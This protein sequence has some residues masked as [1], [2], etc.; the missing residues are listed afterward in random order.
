MPDAYTLCQPCWAELHLISGAVCDGCARP[1]PV[2]VDLAA[3]WA[4]DRTNERLH[5]DECA[6]SLFGWRRVRA[7]AF[8]E[9]SARSLVLALKHGDRPDLA[10]PLARWMARAGQAMIADADLIVP[11]PLHW[12]RRVQR[13]T[14]QAAELS[15]SIARIAKIGHG[16]GVLRRSV[17]T[18]SL[19]HL[20]P[21]SRRRVID[22]VF[23]LAADISG[24][25]IVMVDDVMTSGATLTE[26][27][28]VL[29][30]GGAARIDA[31]VFARAARPL[32]EQEI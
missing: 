22:G 11:I 24:K 30:L 4:A 16:A 6:G 17:S 32:S 1:L 15:R 21:Q 10:K 23:T 14:N 26:A 31:L 3:G 7:A 20:D 13:K 12:R 28:R 8:Y 2:A 27:A 25:R 5:C 9:G 29:E 19:G 18:K